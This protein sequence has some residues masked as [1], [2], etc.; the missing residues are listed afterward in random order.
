MP[1]VCTASPTAIAVLNL[2]LYKFDTSMRS[3]QLA[4]SHWNKLQSCQTAA[5]KIA[6]CHNISSKECMHSESEILPIEMHN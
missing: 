1:E 4:S 2:C 3:L 6:T 5:L